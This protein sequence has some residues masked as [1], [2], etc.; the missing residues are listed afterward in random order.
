MAPII[1]QLV[2]YVAHK[3]VYR[4][5]VE[6]LPA[7]PTHLFFRAM[8]SSKGSL[9]FTQNSLPIAAFALPS[10]SAARQTG[11]GHDVLTINTPA[12][13][14]LKHLVHDEA[15]KPAPDFI[16]WSSQSLRKTSPG[17]G[18]YRGGLGA[19]AELKILQPLVASFIQSPQ[20]K[21]H[22]EIPSFNLAESSEIVLHKS[23]GEKLIITEAVG[24][25]VLDSSDI[26][27]IKTSGGA[28]FGK[29]ESE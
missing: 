18:R 27:I 1:S 23:N 16:A 21:M 3:V 9:N 10:G 14:K 26:L 20:I 6:M 19:H 5:Q 11:P 15:I 29:P 7:L 17:K 12:R 24:Q 4:K 13:G 2:K 25:V 8:D 22:R 28:G